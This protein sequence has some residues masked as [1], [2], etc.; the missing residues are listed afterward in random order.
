MLIKAHKSEKFDFFENLKKF[1][2]NALKK[3]KLQKKR[4]D[5]KRKINFLIFF[6]N[7]LNGNSVTVKMEK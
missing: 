2:E 5:Q 4:F 3:H 1:C 7:S 6:Q